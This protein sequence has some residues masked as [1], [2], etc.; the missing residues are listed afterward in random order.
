[1]LLLDEMFYRTARLSPQPD[2]L[3]DLVLPCTDVQPL[4]TSHSGPRV[5]PFDVLLPF[6]AFFLM[7]LD[8]PTLF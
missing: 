2:H 8:Q 7:H 5:Y 6:E 4:L 3:Q 1:M